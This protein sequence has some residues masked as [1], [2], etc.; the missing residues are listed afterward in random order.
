MKLQWDGLVL[1]GAAGDG[2][3]EHFGR[4]EQEELDQRRWNVIYRGH[5]VVSTF[6]E[7]TARQRLKNLA[8]Q[9]I[10]TGSWVGR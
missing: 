3:R 1:V 8:E 4:V 7:A 2:W 6:S 5:R 10:A 9:E